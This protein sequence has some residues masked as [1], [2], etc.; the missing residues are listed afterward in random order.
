LPFVTLDDINV[1]YDLSGPEDAP[2]ALLGNSLGTNIH[3]W[4]AQAA[5]LSATHRVLRYDLRGHGLTEAGSRAALSIAD[6]ADDVAHLLDALR[7]RSVSFVGLSLS[8][9][10]AQR[11]AAAY[12]ERVEALALC[13]T[14]SRIGTA[15][16]W[17]A[18]IAAV[19]QGGMTA[20]IPAILERWF[21]PRAHAEQPALVRGFATMLE[22]TPAASYVAAC[23][24]VRDADLCADDARIRCPAL[25]IAGS[26][27]AVTTPAMAAE[28]SAAIPGARLHVID[29]CAH[30]ACAQAPAAFNAVL[31]PF[32]APSAHSSAGL[33]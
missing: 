14:A 29:S 18:R 22:R 23:A 31:L 20:V 13:A 33:R 4:D 12:P 3:V 21:T 5:A 6:L 32:L 10:I 28:L 9:M 27:D 25:V 8:G 16:T 26:D 11:F 2:V 30:I 15:Q 17:E 7:L 19:E 24:A 1:Y